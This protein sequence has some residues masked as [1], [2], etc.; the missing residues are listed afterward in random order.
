MLVV[1]IT[2]GI[3]VGKGVATQ[4]FRSRGAAVVDADEVAH[5]LM[6]PGSPVVGE[7][8]DAFGQH[9]LREDGGLDRG[10]LSQAVFG[11]PQAVA[12]LN[13][14]THPHIKAEIR[15]RLNALR[16]EGVARV[17]CLVA[18]LLVE[19]GCEEL[20][21]RLV[22]MVA[23]EEERIRRVVAR[24][25]LSEAEVRQRMAAQL[26]PDVVAQRADWAVDTTGGREVAYRQLEAIWA[27]LIG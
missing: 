5:G 9:V 26:P 25:G 3:G 17:V 27:E 13:A 20:V 4:F 8:A 6:R 7:V 2:G 1:G 12:R 21:D 18:P 22:V 23:D 10:A 24:D 19:A 16:R 14:L 15:R 11:D